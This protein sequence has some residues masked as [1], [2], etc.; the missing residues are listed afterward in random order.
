MGTPV[1][2]MPP[3]GV[4]T[5]GT[6]TTPTS[7]NGTPTNGTPITGANGTVTQP[8]VQNHK[9]NYYNFTSG[10]SLTHQA[11]KWLSVS[12]V[13]STTMA[14]GRGKDSRLY[15][16]PLRGYTLGGATTYAYP[17]DSRDV[18]STNAS[19]IKTWSSNGNETATLNATAGV[20]RKFDK[21][22]SGSTVA[23]INITRFSQNDGL[24]GFSIFPTFNATL[25]YQ[26]RVG[27]GNFTSSVS[28]FSSP[29]LDPLRALVDPRVGVSASL[30]YSREKF[31]VFA[32]GSTALS[33]APAG[34]DAGAVNSYSGSAGSSYQLA[35]LTLIDAGVR[36]TRQTYQAVTVIPAT[37]GA[38]VG[39]T[40]GTR[41]QLLGHPP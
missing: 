10:L 16:P 26:Q 23:G 9:V 2:G 33:V 6:P 27:R 13:A 30:R 40:F 38:F 24:R 8:D 20:S 5:N 7:G 41:V 34:N 37:W 31:S 14:G 12:T 4:P 39:L 1:I 25:S 3:N 36:M 22:T 29:A 32:N 15:Y 17:F 28:A 35:K 21:H 11:S 18:A 19:L